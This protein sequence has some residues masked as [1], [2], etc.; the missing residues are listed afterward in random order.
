MNSRH[1]KFARG[2]V[3]GKSQADAY[4]EAFP[5]SAHW[6]VKAVHS[7]AS[8]LA[9]SAEVSRRVE[10]LRR[11]ADAAA[12][13]DCQELR[14]RLTARIRALDETGGKDVD[15]CRLADSLA[16]VSGWLSPAALAV[17][18]SPVPLS[19]EE[20][21]RRINE[22]LGIPNLPVAE[23]VTPEE[24]ARKIREALGIPEPTPEERARRFREFVGLPEREPEERGRHD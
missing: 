1:E 13:M 10:E 9:K 19:P 7:H 5:R 8:A 3:A 15:F 11:E 16:R 17:A 12:I 14:T 4:R 21:E 18:V 20:R 22:I 6:S 23:K 2:I 24:R